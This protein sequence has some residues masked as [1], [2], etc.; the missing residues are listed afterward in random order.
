MPFIPFSAGPGEC[1]GRHVVLLAGA[2]LRAEVLASGTLKLVGGQ[3]LN[4][5]RDLPGTL[6]HFSLELEFI[7]PAVAEP[8]PH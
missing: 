6:N 5:E 2:A 8:R 3:Q 7:K 4:P 1:S